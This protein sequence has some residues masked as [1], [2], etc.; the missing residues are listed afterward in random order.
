MK[1]QMME[2]VNLHLMMHGDR[3]LSTTWMVASL[4]EIVLERDYLIVFDTPLSN[5]R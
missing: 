4:L 5:R 2:K 3:C 1:R